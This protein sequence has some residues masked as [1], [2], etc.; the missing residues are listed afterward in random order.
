MRT[1]IEYSNIEYYLAFHFKYNVQT[2]K[3]ILINLQGIDLTFLCSLSKIKIA[4]II[5]ETSQ[6]CRGTMIPKVSI[7]IETKTCYHIKIK[8]IDKNLH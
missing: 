5:I 4:S 1:N 7:M 6:A 8:Y 2:L 3:K